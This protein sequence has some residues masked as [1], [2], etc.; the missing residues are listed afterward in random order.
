MAD[1]VALPPIEPMDDRSLHAALEGRRSARYFAHRSLDLEAIGRLVWAAQGVTSPEGHRT[2]PSAGALFP[3]EVDV[4]AGAVLGLIPG[5]YRYLP[6][7]HRLACRVEGDR[8]RA[9]SAAALS[10]ACVSEAPASL[11]ISAVESRTARRYGP[12]ASRY[13]LMEVGAAAENISLAAVALALGTVWVGAFQ[14]S[15]VVDACGLGSNEEPLL[16]VPVGSPAPSP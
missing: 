3:L 16:I 14:D 4:V 8:R 2:T 13:V 15:A 6:R 11:V 9:L 1:S 10:Q 7:R 12:R 5:V